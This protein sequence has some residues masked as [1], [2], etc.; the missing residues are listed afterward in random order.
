MQTGVRSGVLLAVLG[1]WLVMR[2]THQDQSGR[3]LIDHILGK[4]ATGLTPGQKAAG[5]QPGQTAVT[6]GQAIT[7]AASAIE[8]QG[9]VQLQ[10]PPLD[11][12][13]VQGGW[14]LLPYHF[15]KRGAVGSKLPAS[16]SQIQDAIN[17]ITAIGE[18]V[19]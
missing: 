11:P 16:E 9:G 15:P 7:S 17:R 4:T 8:S 6:P 1:L 18:G 3:T 5:V 2:S 13:V 10:A 14:G 19:R 12:S